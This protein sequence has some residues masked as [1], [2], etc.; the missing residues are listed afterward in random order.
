M[1]YDEL[2]YNELMKKMDPDWARTEAETEF[3]RTLKDIVLSGEV[4]ELNE[5]IREYSALANITRKYLKLA[6]KKPTEFIKG[7]P[8]L[9]AYEQKHITQEILDQEDSPPQ[10]IVDFYD[11]GDGCKILLEMAKE[12]PFWVHGDY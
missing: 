1:D 8:T 9:E 6:F 12:N 10:K 4:D 11:N 7:F 3:N 2:D 5:K